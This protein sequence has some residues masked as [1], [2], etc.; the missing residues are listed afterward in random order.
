MNMSTKKRKDVIIVVLMIM[1]VV[2]GIAYSALSSSL[3][4]EGT[5]NIAS[6]FNVRITNI[7]F[8]AGSSKDATDVSTSGVGS[9][10]ASFKTN[11]KK[12]GSYAVYDVT[13]E[14]KGNLNA[15]LNDLV[16]NQPSDSKFSLT[17]S[18]ITE[19]S[20][21]PSS[22]TVTFQV[23]I[24]WLSSANTIPEEDITFSVDLDYGQDTN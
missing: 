7:A 24:E 17:T 2:M 3:R 6:D 9:T 4:V 1:V 15:V 19:S 18:G 5:S 12:P 16:L 10:T 20:K 21:L 22:D 13:V 14:N 8:K 11:L 23:K